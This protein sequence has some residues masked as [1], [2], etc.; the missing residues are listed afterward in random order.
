MEYYAPSYILEM[1]DETLGDIKDEKTRDTQIKIFVNELGFVP[2]SAKTARDFNANP[3]PKCRD[4][5][6]FVGATQNTFLHFLSNH[7]LWIKWDARW[8]EDG[9]W[10][11]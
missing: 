2:I 1:F 4:E 6:Y 3:N 7:G 10:N 11:W 8:D 9:N 5:G